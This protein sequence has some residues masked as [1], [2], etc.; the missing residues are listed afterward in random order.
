MRSVFRYG[1]PHGVVD[2]R[3]HGNDVMDVMRDGKF[4][5][6]LAPIPLVSLTDFPRKR[7][8]VDLS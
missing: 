7:E 4:V 3:F 1:V 6:Y 2:S 8:K 5:S